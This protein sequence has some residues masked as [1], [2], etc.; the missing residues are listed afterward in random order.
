MALVSL[1]LVL[2]A[3]TGGPGC[4]RTCRLGDSAR[5][6]GCLTGKTRLEFLFD[7]LRPELG[8]QVPGCLR[9]RIEKPREII[10]RAGSDACRHPDGPRQFM[11]ATA[12][13]ALRVLP[14]P[15]T[16]ARSTPRG[17]SDAMETPAKFADK[18]AELVATPSSR[19][20]PRTPTTSSP[21]PTTA[22]G[23]RA[24]LLQ[25]GSQEPAESLLA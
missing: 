14:I 6:H 17:R 5:R 13:W 15:R 25:A 21:P 19:P 2:A 1:A 10:P 4:P 23:R 16:A 24:A 18:S 11:A 9:N 3:A 20:T 8:P 12:R 7:R 22:T